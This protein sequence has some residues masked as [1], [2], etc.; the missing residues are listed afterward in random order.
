MPPLPLQHHCNA[1]VKCSEKNFTFLLKIRLE[2]VSQWYIHGNSQTC[3]LVN[4]SELK[5]KVC[6]KWPPPSW[7]VIVIFHVEVWVVERRVSGNYFSPFFSFSL[8]NTL[9]DPNTHG[10]LGRR[11]SLCAV[12]MISSSNM[13][14]N[15]HG[16][17][18]IL[19][20]PFS[21]ALP[22]TFLMDFIRF[23]YTT[24]CGKDALYA[25]TYVCMCIYMY[26]RV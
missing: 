22:F 25:C 18:A 5:S 26:V 23:Y 15:C 3:F 11:Y 12:N 13:F 7:F 4:Q 19:C 10:K 24:T 16:N 8:L 17:F 1:W 21:A 2:F 20:A 14:P 6:R 9:T